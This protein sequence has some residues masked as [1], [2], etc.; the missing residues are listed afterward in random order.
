MVMEQLY[1]EYPGNEAF[2]CMKVVI[3]PGKGEEDGPPTLL[4]I[5]RIENRYQLQSDGRS[6]YYGFDR[7]LSIKRKIALGLSL[8]DQLR[9]DPQYATANKTELE[10]AVTK[11]RSEY[12]LP[13]ECADRYLRQFGREGQYRTISKGMS[14][15]EGR[16]QA[17]IDYSNMHSRYFDDP[18]RR[19]E[20]GVE[21]D[22]IGDIEEAAFD[23]IRLRTVPDMPKLHM[24]MRNL[25]K[26]C[27]TK[28]GKKEIKTIADDVRPILPSSQCFDEQKRPLSIEAIDAKWVSEYKQ[29]I[30]YHLRKAC[31]G[32]ESQ[33]ERETPLELLEAAYKKLNHGDMDLTLIDQKDYKKARALAVDIS[34]RAK[35]LEEQIYHLEKELKKLLHKKA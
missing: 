16:W 31:K 14:D 7:A 6:E 8:E 3:L 1:R 11:C 22:E 19:I 28:E 35:E 4:E 24:I 10:K 23:I 27:G 32:H 13:L 33:K 29:R 5:E 9:D 2:G 21:E 34:N 25:P 15:P 30:T 18:K 20:C 17:F 26:Y 12:L